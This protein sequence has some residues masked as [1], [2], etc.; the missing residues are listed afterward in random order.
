M[1][2]L[3]TIFGGFPLL[4]NKGELMMKQ[5]KLTV[6]LRIAITAALYAALTLAIAPLSYGA[7]Q[8]RISEVLTLLCFYRKDYCYAL[9]LGCAISNLFSPLGAWDMLFG[10]ASTVFTVVGMRYVKNLWIASLLPALSMVF[11]GWELALLGTPFWLSFLT[12]AIGEIG[13]VT[14]IGVPL[15]KTLEKNRHF[16]ET[17]L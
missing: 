6:F 2:L 1:L 9:I 16:K 3:L 13:V 12:A 7:V 5:S 15:F 17:V 14:V 11:I 8:F 4:K 10:V